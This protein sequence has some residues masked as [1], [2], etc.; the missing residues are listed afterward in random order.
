MSWDEHE[1]CDEKIM[2]LRKEFEHW[3]HIAEINGRELETLHEENEK[4]RRLLENIN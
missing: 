3:K 2:K 1:L 4:L